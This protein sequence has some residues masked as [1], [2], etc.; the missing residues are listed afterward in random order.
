MTDPITPDEQDAGDVD[1]AATDLLTGIAHDGP[2]DGSTMTSRRPAGVLLVDRPA[3][4][5][6]LYDWRD[7]AF[8]ARQ[9]GP[10]PVVDDPDADDNRERAA[11]EGLWDVQA[12]P[13][14]GGDPDLIDPDG[15]PDQQPDDD[16]D[17]DQGDATEVTGPVGAGGQEG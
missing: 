12:A 9:T 6:W 3:G 2:L 15:D 16:P 8:Y 7:G 11:E 5:C 13:W 14:V 17:D 10:M 1:P 4:Q